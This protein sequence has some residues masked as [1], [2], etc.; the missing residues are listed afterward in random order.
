MAV[1]W[2]RSR[3]A[4][5]DASVGSSW[6]SPGLAVLKAFQV[7]GRMPDP[8]LTPHDNEREGY[9]PSVVDS[10]GAVL[11]GRELIIPYAMADYASS[12]AT[13]SLDEVLAAIRP[14]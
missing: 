7:L 1:G 9:V 10:C 8:L 5:G 13:V 4:G 6:F 3:D 11:H 12:F 2:R 14:A